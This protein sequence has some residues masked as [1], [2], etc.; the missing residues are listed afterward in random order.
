MLDFVWSNQVGAGDPLDYNAKHFDVA[1]DPLP[2]VRR[3]IAER[4]IRLPE[5]SPGGVQRPAFEPD[6]LAAGAR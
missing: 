3:F 2:I 6:I 4:G 5:R 1:G